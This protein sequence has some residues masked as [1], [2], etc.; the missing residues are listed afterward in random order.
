MRFAICH[1]DVRIDFKQSQKVQGEEGK[2][3]AKRPVA[4]GPGSNI[5]KGSGKE[6]KGTLRNFASTGSWS[7]VQ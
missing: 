7:K 3:W 4:R 6:S 1:G 5:H 2:I